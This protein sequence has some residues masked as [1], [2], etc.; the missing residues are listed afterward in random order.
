M[1]FAHLPAGYLLSRVM[2]QTGKSSIETEA[3]ARL[4]L[5]VGLIGSVLP[6]VDLL[7][8]YLLSDRSIG[9]R[10]YF[11]HWPIFWL[12][13]ASAFAALA[14]IARRP[15]WHMLN[16]F[17]VANILL[18]LAL[19]TIMG[20][21]RWFYPFDDTY[22]RLVT[23]PKRHAWWVWSYMLHWSMW[24]ETMIILTAAWAWR[25]RPSGL[26]EAPL[27]TAVMIRRSTGEPD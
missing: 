3:Q 9:H 23:V 15:S 2:L 19:D 4:L 26:I 27:L 13:V 21:V 12:G 16:L 14:Q 8:F 20:P 22:Y 17:L 6:D 1:I 11:T 5:I 10:S 7:Y 24:L 18:H 25:Y